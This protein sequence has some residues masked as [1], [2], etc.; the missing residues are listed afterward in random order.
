VQE[1]QAQLEA[2]LKARSDFNET[3]DP[4][5]GRPTPVRIQQSIDARN[6]AIAIEE[7]LLRDRQCALERLTASYDRAEARLGPLWAAQARH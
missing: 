5:R 4:Y 6:A 3:H 1:S 2:L 7:A